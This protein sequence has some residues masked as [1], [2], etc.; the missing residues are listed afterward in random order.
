MQTEYMKELLMPNEKSFQNDILDFCVE[1]NRFVCL[2]YNFADSEDS[3]S[4][5]K[6]F[7]HQSHQSEHLLD[8]KAFCVVFVI[9]S[10]AIMSIQQEER[11]KATL[12][13]FVHTLVKEEVRDNFIGKESFRLLKN[14]LNAD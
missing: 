2:P 14:Y 13:L 5:K 3:T 9:E 12:K 11:V 10:Y 4:K 1:D 6:T 8:I 7:K